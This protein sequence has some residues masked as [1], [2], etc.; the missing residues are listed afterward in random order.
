MKR[1][2]PARLGRSLSLTGLALM[3]LGCASQTQLAATLRKATTQ[4]QLPEVVACYERQFERSGFRG[5]YLA[6]M[7]FTI[8]GGEVQNSTVHELYAL[9]NDSLEASDDSAASFRACLKRAFD[10]TQLSKLSSSSTLQVSGFRIAFK[11]ASHTNDAAINQAPNVLVGP[12]ANRCHG[13]YSHEPPRDT[14]VLFAAL[15]DAQAE[16]ANARNAKSDQTARTLQKSYDLALELR[17]RL[18]AD[19][20][21]P[22]LPSSSRNR[23]YEALDRTHETAVDIGQ[24]INCSPPELKR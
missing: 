19:T 14:A 11:A 23:L 21:R 13:L 6:L 3:L 22:D 20:R 24:K 5:E 8:D 4:D 16:A 17:E 12:R 9:A 2:A 1:P 18:L 10:Q 7:S 15:S